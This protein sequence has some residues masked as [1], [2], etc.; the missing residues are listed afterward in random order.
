VLGD[1][2]PGVAPP[3]LPPRPPFLC[4]GLPKKRAV[5]VR[6][7]PGAQ[8]RAAGA[9]SEATRSGT[10]MPIESSSVARSIDAVRSVSSS[11]GLMAG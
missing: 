2:K 10:G 7:E 8:R 5:G 11:L 4:F 1:A 3:P 6:A 9:R